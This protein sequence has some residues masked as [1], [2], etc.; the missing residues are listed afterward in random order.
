MG[1]FWDPKWVFWRGEQRCK[2]PCIS[3]SQNLKECLHTGYYSGVLNTSPV[4]N[5]TSRGVRDPQMHAVTES[6]LCVCSACS[7]SHL[8]RWGVIAL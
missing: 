6:V 3:F 8:P 5:F 2:P 4:P 7:P 1:L